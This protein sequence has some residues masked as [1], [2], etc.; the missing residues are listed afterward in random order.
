MTDQA[1]TGEDA[2]PS[3]EG[4]A[5][6]LGIPD[7]IR[8]RRAR[9]DEALEREWPDFVAEARVAEAALA[10]WLGILTEDDPPRRAVVLAWT[11]T[12]QAVGTAL[13]AERFTL[14]NDARMEIL[15]NRQGT[16]MGA[17]VPSDEMVEVAR[18]TTGGIP[19]WMMLKVAIERA[20]ADFY[21]VAEF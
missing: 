2:T 18:F 8:E 16:T 19:P 13:Y 14:M 5:R 3:E 1:A 17:P 21:G 20:W 7:A 11:L 10:P 9:L 15:I 4:L 6:Y 12:D